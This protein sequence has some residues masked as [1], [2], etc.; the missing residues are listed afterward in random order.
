MQ[1]SIALFGTKVAPEVRE[2]LEGDAARS[3]EF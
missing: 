3:V 1:K 2:L